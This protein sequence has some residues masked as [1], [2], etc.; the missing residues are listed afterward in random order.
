MDR[1]SSQPSLLEKLARCVYLIGAACAF[2]LMI[3]LFAAAFLEIGKSIAVFFHFGS[4][5]DPRVPPESQALMVALKGIE[6]LFLAPIGF[7]VYRSLA[8]YVV[9]KTRGRTDGNAEAEVTEAKRLV[10]SLM[11]AVVATDLIGRVL[12]PEGFSV[13]APVYELALLIV[14]GAYMFLLHII[15]SRKAGI[16]DN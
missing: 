5:P 9:D 15:S 12:S 11:F 4:G 6:Y 13:R 3:F 7:L 10:T 8:M 2:A 1:E 16:A 14:L